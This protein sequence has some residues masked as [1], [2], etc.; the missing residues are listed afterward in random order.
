MSGA[1]GGPHPAGLQ[2]QAAPQGQEPNGPDK[3]WV[4]RQNLSSLAQRHRQKLADPGVSF[5]D[6]VLSMMRSG[7]YAPDF[8]WCST[9]AGGLHFERSQ[10]AWRMTINPQSVTPADVD[11]LFFPGNPA[12]LPEQEEL[13]EILAGAYGTTQ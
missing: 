4:T 12:G 10:I 11:R 8:D 5:K 2:A 1:G 9:K 7:T 6:V 13:L 3:V